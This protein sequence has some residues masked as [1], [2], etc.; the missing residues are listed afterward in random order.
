MD[1]GNH[2]H[3]HLPTH[4][5]YLDSKNNLVEED[6]AVYN[7]ELELEKD[8]SSL[9]E[10]LNLEVEAGGSNFSLGQ[11]QLI[12]IARAIVRKP[13]ILLM[14]EATASIDE[15]TDEIIQKIIADDMPNTTVITIAHRLNTVMAYDKIMVLSEG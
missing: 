14:D 10:M 9:E 11:R 1:D 5:Q 4:T 7:G 2:R 6:D 15:K 12:C 13:K 8:S 3:D